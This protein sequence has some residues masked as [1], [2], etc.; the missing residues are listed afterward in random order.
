MQTAIL[1]IQATNQKNISLESRK[2]S[3]LHL[4]YRICSEISSCVEGS[5]NPTSLEQLFTSYIIAYF[6]ETKMKS[7]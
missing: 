5:S 2:S 3:A 1:D 4:T 7:R 6:K